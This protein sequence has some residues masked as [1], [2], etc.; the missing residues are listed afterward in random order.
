MLC[1]TLDCN[2]GSKQPKFQLIRHQNTYIG[3]EQNS[4]PQSVFKKISTLPKFEVIS[5]S[6]NQSKELTAAKV[7]KLSL[8]ILH[9]NCQRQM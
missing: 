3:M 1:L 2:F 7:N 5:V 6:D 4:G 8:N 9:K